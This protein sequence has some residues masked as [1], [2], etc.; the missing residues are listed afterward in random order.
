MEITAAVVR[1][2][3]GTFKVEQLELDSPRHDE[4]LVRIVGVGLCHTDL[5]CRDQ[6]YPVP[7]PA[8][9]GHEGA[10]VVEAVGT[11]VTDL[12]PGDHV[13]LSFNACGECSNCSQG[14]PSRCSLLFESNFAGARA[15]GSCAHSCGDQAIHGHFFAQ[16][17]FASHALAHRRNTVKVDADVP[18][19]L[20]GP[21]GCGVQTGAGAVMNTLAPAAGSS[22]AV[23]GCGSVG[24]SAVM[25]ASL[26]GCATIIAVEPH[27][28]RRALALELGATH[29]IDPEDGDVVEAIHALTPEGTDYS[30]ECTANPRV[31]RQAVDA[32]TVTGTCALIGAAPMGTE[33]TLDMNSI[34]FGRTVTG[35]IEGDSIPGQFIP[36]L[37][38]LHKQGR[39]PLD[40]LVTFY[41]LTAI[42]QAVEDSEAGRVVKAVLQP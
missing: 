22:I 14:R 34:M 26:V 31:L 16:S 35:V 13:V 8:V 24:L 18:L 40:K 11:G 33:V 4:V 30:L 39:F 42:Q 29:T 9:L 36:K 5:I 10:G 3:G 28:T 2:P 38:A 19:E 20:L 41:P 17:S 25:A 12:E 15:D 32:L 7:L 27:A 23:F 37:V 21:L 1:E 6:L